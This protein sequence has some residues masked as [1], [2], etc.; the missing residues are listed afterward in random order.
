MAP[1]VTVPNTI[2]APSHS[3]TR[4]GMVHRLPPLSVPLSVSFTSAG[5]SRVSRPVL[6]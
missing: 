5:W 1:S 3:V 4:D 2:A 6:A